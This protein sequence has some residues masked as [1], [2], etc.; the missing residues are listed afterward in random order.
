MT[1]PPKLLPTTFT[2][3]LV[4][5]AVVA[6][7]LCSGV[8]GAQPQGPDTGLGAGAE[9][10]AQGRALIRGGKLKQAEETL[11]KAAKAR[12]QSIESLYELARVTFASGDIKQAKNACKALS[13]KDEH[14]VLTAVCQARAFLL[15][16]RASRAQEFL[17]QARALDASHPEVLLAFADTKRVA[18]ET[19]ASKDAYQQLL[20]I[21]PDNADAYFGLGELNLVTPDLVAAKQAFANA[22]SRAPEWPDALYELGK[23]ESGAQAVTMLEK[24]LAARPDWLEARLALGSARLKNG[25]SAG[26]EQVLREVL[27]G[28]PDSALAHAQLGVA[29]EAKHDLVGAEPELRLGL[30]TLPNDIDANLALARVLAQ[31]D[32]ADDAFAQFRTAAGLERLAPRA[33]IEAGVYALSISRNALA[34]AFLAKAVERAPTSALAQ[35][36]YA[37]ALLARGDKPAAKEHYKLALAGEGSIDR[38]DIQRRL[39][40]LK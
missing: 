39:A 25:D 2:A 30:T 10:T 4:R 20:G 23:L 19:S 35:A 27:R 5:G 17:D 16:R 11:L 37:D 32:R 28:H 3:T 26:S 21:E 14:A 31:T 33:L 1:M 12:G 15:W 8:A 9:L 38:A 36:R 13:A 6:S 22:L 7:L 24:A 29:L 34:E 18:G 40:A